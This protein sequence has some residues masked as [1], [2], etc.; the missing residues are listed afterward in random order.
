MGCDTGNADCLRK[1]SKHLPNDFLPKAFSPYAIGAV[2][3]PKNMAIQDV[4]C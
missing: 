4:S 3:R 2:Y 1:L